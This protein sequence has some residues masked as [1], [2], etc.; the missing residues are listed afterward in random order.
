[1][2]VGTVWWAD[3][4]M[5]R[6][7]HLRLLD[8]TERRR[9]ATIVHPRSRRQS[10]LG[11]VLL[12][13]AVARHTGASADRL[14][15]V[16]ACPSCPGQ[17]GRPR[18]PDHPVGVSVSHSGRRVAVAVGDHAGADG[19]T[20]LGVDVE[21]LDPGRPPADL[22][23]WCR[24]EAVVKATGDG[25]R[26]RVRD[27]TVT[28]SR[29]LGYPGRPELR[30]HLWD[31]RPG[32]GYRAAAALVGPPPLPPRP[33]IVERSAAALLTGRRRRPARGVR[34][35]RRVRLARRARCDRGF[36]AA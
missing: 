7:W 3:L 16:R 31:L 2:P 1:M 32:P 20:G 10:T 8:D 23:R 33:R 17:H 11:A 22:A 25:L 9:L 14:R 15:V 5:L 29:L 4:G 26:V 13:L 35:A 36:P 21:R 28:R 6:P 12:R 19:W 34:R 30:G 24:Q 18:L 27:V